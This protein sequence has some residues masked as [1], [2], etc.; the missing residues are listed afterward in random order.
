MPPVENTSLTACQAFE[1]ISL[2]QSAT[3]I[4][5]DF[6]A[7]HKSLKNCAVAENADFIFVHAVVNI[8][9]N[10]LPT[11]EKMSLIPVHRFENQPITAFQ[12]DKIPSQAA[13]KI[14]V[15]HSATT[16]NTSFMPCH[17]PAKKSL[18][19]VQTSVTQSTNC[20]IV[21][22][23][24]SHKSIKNCFTVS[25]FLYSNTPI[26]ISAPIPRHTSV[27]GLVKKLTA[28]PSAVINGVN[29]LVPAA[30]A[31]NALTTP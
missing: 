10:Q 11:A 14:P 1:N 7:V 23:K 19:D 17:I 21:I 12:T 16:A 22:L 13:W 18:I 28:T 31:A 2:N 8:S 3:L 29:T 6:I 15:N 24:L 20:C 27:I 26:A 5:G 4:N 25:Q 9:P 30:N